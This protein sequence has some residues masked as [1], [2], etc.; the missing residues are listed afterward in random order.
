MLE[1]RCY[2]CGAILGMGK[3]NSLCQECETIHPLVLERKESEVHPDTQRLDWLLGYIGMKK[4]PGGY[5]HIYIDSPAVAEITSMLV[6]AWGQIDSDDP[7]EIIDK[8]M[9]LI[10]K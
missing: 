1:G 2:R 5:K 8:A 7:R 4:W 3:P 6:R 10:D 9:E